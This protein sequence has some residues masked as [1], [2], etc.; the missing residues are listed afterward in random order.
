MSSCRQGKC[1]VVRDSLRL[2][3]SKDIESGARRAQLWRLLFENMKYLVILDQNFKGQVLGS[4]K[5][6]TVSC[7][8]GLGIL[9]NTQVNKSATRK[10]QSRALTVLGSPNI[11]RSDTFS[12]FFLYLLKVNRTHNLTGS[13]RKSSSLLDLVVHLLRS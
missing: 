1:R 9:A 11:C 2:C 10:A 5:M 3:L 8:S 13:L 4:A 12:C 7:I 6:N